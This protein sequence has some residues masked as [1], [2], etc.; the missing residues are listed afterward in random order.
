MQI[1]KM[2]LQEENQTL[3]TQLDFLR[4][5]ARRGS[6]YF[7][8][9]KKLCQSLEAG[10]AGEQK[11]LTYIQDYGLSDWSVL[12]NAWL[13]SFD[14]FEC[15]LI[16][17]TYRTVYLLEIKNYKGTFHYANGKC[18]YDTIETSLNP[19]EQARKNLVNLK[20]ICT[21][22][23][24]HLN[25]K[26]AVIF[27]GEDHEVHID[28]AP[29]DI[30]IVTSNGIRNFI[31]DIVK[32]EKVSP[33]PTIDA[34]GLLK[35]LN[36]H[37]IPCPYLPKPLTPDEMKEV[38]P[39]IQCANCHSFNVKT[40]KMKVICECGL[41]ESRE[42]A[43][44]RTICD[45][46]VLTYDRNFNRREL[47]C[48]F[49]EQISRNLLYETIHKHFIVVQNGRGTYYVNKKLP[50]EKIFYLFQFTMP[51]TFQHKNRMLSIFQI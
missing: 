43:I 17:L 11:V 21:K 27:A 3:P 31:L 50:Y 25:V 12:Q 1:L 30:R 7:D 33:Q 35:I 8:D 16:L 36:Q 46:G 40:T 39:G 28:S 47:L 18:Y 14:R 9:N 42:E 20:Q 38:R 23:S 44:V 22:L 51:K 49:D 5:L 15:D 24:P 32:N 10:H 41:T 29:E 4:I 13:K 45:Y 26:T 6:N 19:I 37:E 48:F 34:N 2:K